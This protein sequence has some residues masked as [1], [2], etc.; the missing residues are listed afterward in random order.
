MNLFDS[1]AGDVNTSGDERIS[2]SGEDNVDDD[3]EVERGTAHR[4][5]V[6]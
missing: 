6:Y 2:E 4:D 5:H 3:Q 1:Q